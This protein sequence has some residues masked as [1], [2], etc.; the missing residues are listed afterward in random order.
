MLTYR[1]ILWRMLS[2]RRILDTISLIALAL[3]T[4][5]ILSY[6]PNDPSFFSAGAQ[7]VKNLLGVYGAYV[8]G[9]VVQIIGYAWVPLVL[10]A[11]I[12]SVHHI[13]TGR[14]G[15]FLLLRVALLLLVLFSFSIFLCG[16]ASGKADNTLNAV[17][18]A[19]GFLGYYW[20]NLFATDTQ[21]SVILF[22]SGAISFIALVLCLGISL[23]EYRQCMV[24]I[25]KACTMLMRF[26]TGTLHTILLMRHA[27]RT[28]RDVCVELGRKNYKK[29]TKRANSTV[30]E[31][32][33]LFNDNEYAE[34]PY[35]TCNG[36]DHN[37]N[38]NNTSRAHVKNCAK[39]MG[40]A[41]EHDVSAQYRE[42][43]GFDLPPTSL[44]QSPPDKMR[45]GCASK[46]EIEEQSAQLSQVL[47]DFGVRGQIV[48]VYPGPVVV[49]YELK[50]A[51]GTKSSRIISLADDIA[52][53]MGAI[54]A[55]IAVIPG[56]DAI[57]IELPNRTRQV[58]YLRYM[59]EREEYKN[60]NCSLPL[61]LGENIGG[62]PVVVDLAKMPHLLVAG[63]T[64]SGKSVAIN[65]MI[66]SL[67]YKYGPK[68]C[69]VIMIDPKMLELSMYD[70][71]PHLL[72]PVVTNP[73][74]AVFA[75][76]W[77]VREMESR[78][79]AMSISGIRNIKGYNQLV[80]EAIHTGHPIER[81]VQV[82]FDNETN[83]P[84]FE[85]VSIKCERL[86][87]IVII[88]DEMADLML[89]AGKEI[90]TYV[91]RL[92]QMAR[93][94]GIHIIMATQR[95]SVDVI[96]GV[97]KANF[98]TRISFQVTSKIDSRTILGEQGAEQLLG[99]GDMLCMMPGGRIERI[100]GPFVHDSEVRDVVNFLKEQSGTEYAADFVS[101]LQNASDEND[102]EEGDMYSS[103]YKN[104]DSNDALYDKAVALVLKEKRATTSYLQRCFKI[105]YNR[106]AILMDRMESEGIVSAPNQLGKREILK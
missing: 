79:R 41:K 8:A 93:A 25:W 30:Q 82:G 22:A 63:T 38:G 86:P 84:L 80:E 57:G 12:E 43:D 60:T 1:V 21:R 10:C 97:I 35:T 44:L 64:G 100:H 52:R 81:K 78:Y 45:A 85:V 20:Y 94:A 6:S 70:G 17:E 28:K 68:D 3:F 46:S 48:A 54:S 90:E 61:V 37:A 55:R 98:P 33:N 77:A 72:A 27:Q 62:E 19:G 73:K 99:M 59:L 101:E 32:P 75:L 104:G 47:N 39:S 67:L 11:A 83:S 14:S 65:T 34:A 15:K 49:L 31:E 2:H 103:S 87:Y 96:T 50:P 58:I 24:H 29:Y 4:I 40:Y 56:K 42:G 53:S 76:K 74:K 13:T 106:A 51:A 7:G 71:I 5:A 9:F 92:A 91:Q 69:R 105:G 89:V 88:V 36:T 26:T 95:P 16:M 102:E 23:R 66:L 18:G